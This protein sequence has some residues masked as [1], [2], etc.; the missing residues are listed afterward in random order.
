[1]EESNRHSGST[2][3]CPICSKLRDVEWSTSKFGWEDYGASFPPEAGRLVPAEPIDSEDKRTRHVEVCPLCGTYYA[4][5][6]SY[7]YLADGSEDTHELRR[8]STEE[9]LRRLAGEREQGGQGGP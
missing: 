4:Y 2:S 6:Y 8:I 7:E 1:M 9:A 3:S 5:S